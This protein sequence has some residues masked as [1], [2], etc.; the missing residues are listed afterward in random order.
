MDGE[1]VCEDRFGTIKL[2]L[3]PLE[4]QK[5]IAA[6]I[7]ITL[8]RL[9][10]TEGRIKREI[11]LLQE[12]RTRLIADLVTGKL[13]VREAAANL[14]DEADEPEAPDAFD[15]PIDD[16]EITDDLNEIPEEAEA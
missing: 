5:K 15:D 7:A 13:D 4:E 9:E 14:P 2:P 11:D 8:G 6:W 1:F 12:Y 16:E 3:P 10:S